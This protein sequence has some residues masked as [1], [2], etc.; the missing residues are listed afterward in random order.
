[1]I[2]TDPRLLLTHDSTIHIDVLTTAKV[3]TIL[4]EL[5]KHNLHAEW[6]IMTS[7]VDHTRYFHVNFRSGDFILVRPID[8]LINETSTR[9]EINI[10]VTQNWIHMNT[11]KVILIFD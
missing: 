8:E 4:L 7:H 2:N 1:M 10:N 11:I 3:G 9:I 5:K 6:F